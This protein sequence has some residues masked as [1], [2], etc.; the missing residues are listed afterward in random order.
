[1]QHLQCQPTPAGDGNGGGSKDNFIKQ[2]SEQIAM[3]MNAKGIQFT[4]P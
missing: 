4:E 3:D 1:M 2:L